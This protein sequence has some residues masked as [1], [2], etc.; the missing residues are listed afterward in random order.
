MKIIISI[1]INP[2]QYIMLNDILNDNIIIQLYLDILRDFKNTIYFIF[3]II[4]DKININNTKGNHCIEFCFIILYLINIV[5]SNHNDVLNI[6][7]NNSKFNKNILF[8][9]KYKHIF[10]KYN[11]IYKILFEATK[12]KPYDDVK[13]YDQM[14]NIL[15]GKKKNNFVKKSNKHK[16]NNRNN[17]P[18]LE[19][20][21]NNNVNSFFVPHK[22]KNYNYLKYIRN[23]LLQKQVQEI[24]EGGEYSHVYVLLFFYLLTTR[25]IK[26]YEYTSDL[27]NIIF[28]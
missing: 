15:Y 23:E 20:N 2:N 6:F 5:Y 19:N 13:I 24:Q 4:K 18:N 28:F 8:M 17:T 26:I 25:C 3:N 21:N 11:K 27:Q 10:S 14:K 7:L 12:S 9:E 22:G 1:Y 16:K